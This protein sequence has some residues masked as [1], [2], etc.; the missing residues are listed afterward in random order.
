[1]AFAFAKQ[2]GAR[3]LRPGHSALKQ[4][5]AGA[6][7]LEDATM[8]DPVTEAI[9]TEHLPYELDM[10][11]SAFL[12]LL[13]QRFSEQ[14]KLIFVRNAAIECFWTHARN[15]IEFLTHPASGTQIGTVSA[16][17]FAPKF[18][19]QTIM[20][21]M[22]KRIN[23]GVTHLLYERAEL[24]KIKLNGYDMLRVKE[25]IDREISR[26]EKEMNPEYRSVWVPRN[27]SKWVV[28]DDQTLTATNS[29]TSTSLLIGGGPSGFAPTGPG[30]R[31]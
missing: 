29:T 18:S 20:K 14:R 28:A 9:L 5:D 21:E 22:D 4:G 7:R 19:P 12:V 15:L 31:N 16:R 24:E 2:T 26:F 3:G 6:A 1:L 23:E 10:F 17:D 8:I 13:D 30:S 27:P 25:H 11:E